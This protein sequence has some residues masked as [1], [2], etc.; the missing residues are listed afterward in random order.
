M[1]PA[2]A[3][4]SLRQGNFA[5]GVRTS[6][7][8]C[9]TGITL[10]VLRTENDSNRSVYDGPQPRPRRNQADPSISSVKNFFRV[11]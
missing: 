1:S 2:W 7:Q 10:R 6:R 4:L 5:E 9:A 8:R 3:A 11:Q